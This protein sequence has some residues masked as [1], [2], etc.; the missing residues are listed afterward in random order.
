MLTSIFE[1]LVSALGELLDWAIAKFLEVLN[2]NLSAYL[3]M[4]PLLDDVYNFA[5]KFAMAM[6]LFIAGRALALF[7]THSITGSNLSDRP[8]GV[9]LRTLFGAI[10]IYEGGYILEFIVRMGTIPYTEAMNLNAG[11]PNGISRWVLAGAA[12]LVDPTGVTAA[13]DLTVI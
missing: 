3:E 4:F 12:E 1:Y 8:A 10:A 2:M 6:L 13:A 9:L 5:Q 11:T 7:W